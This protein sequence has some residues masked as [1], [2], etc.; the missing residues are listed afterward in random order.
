MT[1]LI[2]GAN[3]QL[4]TDVSRSFERAGRDVIGLTHA[5]LDIA[6]A[7]AVREVLETTKPRSVVN[8]AAFHNVEE[9]EARPDVAFDVNTVAVHYLTQGCRTNGARL[10]HVSTD[11]VFEGAKDQPYTEEDPAGPVNVYGVSKRAG[12]MLLEMSTDDWV[13]VRLASLFGTTPP[14]GKR[15]NFID[16]IL[17][18]ARAGQSLQAV[19]DQF[20]S[21]TYAAD[22]ADVIA[23]LATDSAAGG[24][25]HVT[26]S[27][28]CSWYDLAK[29]ILKRAGMSAPLEP[30]PASTYPATARRPSNSAL[31]SLRL[32]ADLQMRD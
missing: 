28:G 25:F 4:G 21:P 14:R 18:K 5:D 22:A 11:Y 12:E 6:N 3:G 32:S 24:L 10:V 17:G 16:A 26:N 23:A 8:C 31:S 2:I 27:G 1:V 9:C 15:A 13:C 19:D 20:M 30:V 29:Y 7:A